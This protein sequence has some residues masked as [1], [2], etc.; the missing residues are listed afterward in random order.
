MADDA[1][2]NKETKQEKKP[3]A[4]TE[5]AP[6]AEKG[7]PAKGKGMFLWL[8][9]GVMI[10]A[11]GVGGFAIS[12]LMGGSVPTDPNA[13]KAKPAAASKP[14]KAE[15]KKAEG[16]KAEKKGGEGGKAEGAAPEPGKSWMYD[17]LDA[18]V[19]NLNEPG[20][21]RYVRVTVILE[22]NGQADY[23]ETLSLLDEKKIVLQ[24]WMTTYLAG[25][26]LEDVRGSR[27][28]NRI[29]R[30]M[31]DQFNQLLFGQEKTNVEKVLFKEFAV[32]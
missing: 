2:E 8:I 6:P 7:A 13:V 29:K 27:S 14:E 15:G 25:L 24:D 11:C 21:T 31:L 19:A 16:K 22:I 1:K 9:L 20:V 12:Q 17:K 18:V 23:T 3:E 32:Q 10:L 5:A 30:E 26:S 28:L 4:K